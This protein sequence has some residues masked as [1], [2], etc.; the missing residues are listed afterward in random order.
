[1]GREWLRWV[2]LAVMGA[3]GLALMATT[4]RF[5]TPATLGSVV[6]L[7]GIAGILAVGQACALIGG[8]F[9]LSQGAIVGLAA[10]MAGAAAN[11]WGWPPWGAAGVALATGMA[12]G[13]IN[14]ACVAW[15]GTGPFVTTLST[16]LVYRGLTF[17]LLGGR[18]IGGITAFAWLDRR[19]TVGELRLPYR[20]GLFVA[21]L[22]IAWFVLRATVFGRHVYAVGGN[23]K[24]AW[25]AGV[26]VRRVKTATFAA[27][28]LAAG[29]AAVSLLAWLRVAKP[30]TGVGYELDAIAACVVGGIS[31]QGGRGQ[32]VG[33]A[34]GC[35]VLQAL[36][37][38]ITM[39]GFPD[40]YRSLATG[41]VILAFAAADAMA[42]RGRD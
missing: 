27:S 14:G 1:M 17:A 13:A 35:L 3:A 19:W 36:A 15:A 30:D 42:R 8:G 22:V 29:A 10:A 37:S 38:L 20:T 6:G 23:P 33:A 32:V 12:L 25:L 40:Q 24:A 9:D 11:W 34:V 21:A 5:L 4:E 41:L 26:P 2:P 28:G 18:T 39:S 7:A 16:T 31:L